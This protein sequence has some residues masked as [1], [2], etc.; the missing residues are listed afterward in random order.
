MA[1]SWRRSLQCRE[2][3]VVVVTQAEE[4]PVQEGLE[5]AQRM[6]L[7]LGRWPELLVVNG[8]YPP[9][10]DRR[11]SPDSELT[12]L[13][14]T[15]RAINERELG[16]LGA[17]WRGPRVEL[18]FVP[19]DRGP[20]LPRR[21]RRSC[22]TLWPRPRCWYDTLARPFA[23][24]G[25]R[26]GRCRQDHAR[27]R[28]RARG[29]A[30]RWHTLVMTF[31]P[32]MR[33]RTRSAWASGQREPGGGDPHRH[34]REDVGQ[35][36]RC[37]ATFDRLVRRYAPDDE[38]ATRSSPTACMRTCPARWPAFSSNMAVERLFEVA[39]D[40]RY[41]CVVLDHAAHAAG[42]RLP[43]GARSDHRVSRQR[44]RFGSR[45]SHGSTGKGHSPWGKPFRARGAA[46]S[47]SSTGSWG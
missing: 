44:A 31:D 27:S 20:S 19:I 22:A 14:H 25:G 42:A 40:G 17:L 46:W 35:P 29:R 39:S 28:A 23:R 15:R 34:A 32:S 2:T 1:A 12:R 6:Q 45:S 7:S 26:I 21:S 41:D 11:G 10:R 47:I 9:V 33:L 4:M 30:P 8:L 38:A 16:R 3:G 43:R 36:A 18:P 24:R 13:W 37:A 5:L